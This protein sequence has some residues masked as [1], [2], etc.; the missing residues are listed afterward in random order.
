MKSLLY[1]DNRTILNPLPHMA[2]GL[3][4]PR[5]A[6]QPHPLRFFCVQCTAFLYGGLGGA[7]TRLA[8]ASPVCQLRST[9]HPMLDIIRWWFI[10][11]IREA[12]MNTPLMGIISPLKTPKIPNFISDERGKY[13]TTRALTDQQI[14]K[15]AKVL[16]DK[17]FSP[18]AAISSVESM[19]TWLQIHYQDY[20]HEVFAGIFLTASYTIIAHEILFSGTINEANIYPR[21][22][23]KRALQL[24]AAALI[25]AHNHPSG[26]VIPSSADKAITR[27]LKTSLE[28]PWITLSS[29]KAARFLSPH[30]N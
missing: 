6:A 14:I 24:N 10:T 5:E 9:C 29:A 26:L 19:K 21:E 25:F 28:R 18:G 4:I 1:F 3:D 11:L 23:V 7:A 27:K 30:T 16:L 17:S 20:E 2:V 12:I 15:A 8:G 22:V 13:R